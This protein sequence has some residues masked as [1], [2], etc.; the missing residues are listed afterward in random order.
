MLTGSAQQPLISKLR[1][2]KDTWNKSSRKQRKPKG[3]DELNRRHL[4]L[5]S[6]ESTASSQQSWEDRRRLCH[7]QTSRTHVSGCGACLCTWSSREEDHR[8]RRC[9]GW[10]HLTKAFPLAKCRQSAGALPA[11]A[12]FAAQTLQTIPF[13]KLFQGELSLKTLRAAS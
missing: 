2:H 8:W 1:K 9:W 13:V 10:A 4:E 7:Q 12:A 3:K 11:P 6:T 5:S